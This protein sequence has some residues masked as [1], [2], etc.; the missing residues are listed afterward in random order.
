MEKC[1]SHPGTCLTFSHSQIKRVVL[2]EK[3]HKHL[4]NSNAFPEQLQKTKKNTQILLTGWNLFPVTTR[5]AAPWTS[6]ITCQ[7]MK[8][9]NLC[10]R[11]GRWPTLTLAWSTSSS[12]YPAVPAGKI[13]AEEP[14]SGK[15]PKALPP[16]L[17]PYVCVWN[18]VSFLFCSLL[19]MICAMYLMV[20]VQEGVLA[21]CAQSVRSVVLL[22]KCWLAGCWKGSII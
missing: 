20:I 4:T 12:E 19:V 14:Q 1:S 7:G 16:L 18:F 15:L 10:P 5:Q 17:F 6:E 3:Q 2:S 8:P 9:W 13:W 22:T 21:L 11:T